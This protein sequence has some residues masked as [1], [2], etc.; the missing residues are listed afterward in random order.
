MGHKDDVPDVHHIMCHAGLQQ[1][2][3]NTL[4][5]MCAS[6]ADWGH[7]A[8]QAGRV[9]HHDVAAVNARHSSESTR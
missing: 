3:T 2:Q 4:E 6:S 8:H 1:R 5:R 9:A 7:S